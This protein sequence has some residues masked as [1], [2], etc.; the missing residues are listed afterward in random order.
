MGI[1]QPY[2]PSKPVTPN[3]TTTPTPTEPTRAISPGLLTTLVVVILAGAGFFGWNYMQNKKPVAAPVSAP[4]AITPKITKSITP[5]AT[6]KSDITPI[7]TID[8]FT[9]TKNDQLFSVTKSEFNIAAN[10]TPSILA[11][12]SKD[13]GN[14]NTEA[15]FK[16]LLAKFLN[17]DK[18]IQYEFKYNGKTQDTV[19]WYVTVIPNKPNYTNLATFKKDFDVCTAGASYYPTLVSDK[20]LL[21]ESG[22]G[23]VDNGSGLPAGCNVIQEAVSPTIK[24]K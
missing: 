4:I 9:Y 8:E 21:F 7:T 11:E 1:Y 13:C 15:Y 18:G 2:Q 22:C 17:T 23:G 5:T 3:P 12:D 10:F 20:Y 24:L 14:N 6:S 19:S 16:N